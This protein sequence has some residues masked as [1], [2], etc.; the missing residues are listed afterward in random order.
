MNVRDKMLPVLRPHGG[1][2]EA[3]ALK[4]VIYSGWWG[5]GKLVEQ[6]E[7]KFAE[8]VG[9]KYA[10]AV[11]SNTLGQDLIY[12]AYRIHDCDVI[13]PTISFMTTGIVPL[14]NNCRSLLVDCETDTL[15]I[16]PLDVN[17]RLTG[18]TGAIVVVNMAGVPANIDVIRIMYPDGLIIEDCAHSCY[19]KGAGKKGDV[20]VWS[21]QAVKTLPAGD[22]GMIT[23]D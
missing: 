9:S 21:F 18:N 4:E 16:D 12:K 22:G 23:T 11:T 19:V 5:K 2:E 14:W 6:F 13:S 17:R 3:E 20:A 10:V 7:E 1:E 15:N 8:M